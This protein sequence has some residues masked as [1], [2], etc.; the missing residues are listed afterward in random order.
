MSDCQSWFGSARSNRCSGR[1][2]LGHGLRYCSRA[3][4]LRGGSAAPSSPRRPG[5]GSAPSRPGS[6]A[7]RARDAPA[8]PPPPLPAADP[9][10][11]DEPLSPFAVATVHSDHRFGS[12]PQRPVPRRPVHHRRYRDAE[13]LCHRRRRRASVHHRLRHLQ[14]H[15]RWPL[16][17]SGCLRRCSR[18]SRL[19]FIPSSLSP[20]SVREKEGRL[21]RGFADTQQ[22]I[23]RHAA[24]TPRRAARTG[25]A[26]GAHRESKATRNHPTPQPPVILAATHGRRVLPRPRVR[27][28]ARPQSRRPNCE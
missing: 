17:M 12:A 9:P 25:E 23:N 16:P 27:G 14:P 28:A 13:G 19:G 1:T 8:A 21:L 4:L 3:A 7:C 26:T 2:R 24:R 10:P 18:L 20:R 6:A 22:C 15:L 5:P 11:D